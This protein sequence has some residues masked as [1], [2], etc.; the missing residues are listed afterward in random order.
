MMQNIQSTRLYE[1]L[2]FL[3]PAH[4]IAIQEL[5]QLSFMN[6]KKESLILLDCILDHIR[7]T[8]QKPLLK[9][10]LIRACLIKEENFNRTMSKLFMKVRQAL[11]L[12]GIIEPPKLSLEFANFF[13]ENSLP[14]NAAREL[15][16]LESGIKK[17]AIQTHDLYL[18]KSK[19]HAFCLSKQI[20]NR[21]ATPHLLLMNKSLDAFYAGSKLQLLC[22]HANRTRII[23]ASNS[24]IFA[25]GSTA[26]FLDLLHQNNFFESGNIKTYYY[27]Y[28]MLTENEEESYKNAALQFRNYHDTN[29]LP[30]ELIETFIAYLMNQCIQFINKTTRVS[31][32]A[33]HY[34]QYLELLQEEDCLLSKGKLRLSRFQGAI[35]AASITGEI[36]WMRTF[37]EDYGSLLVGKCTA[38]FKEIHLAYI[39]KLVGNLQLAREQMEALVLPR[40]ID[41]L[42]ALTYYKTAIEIYYA[43]KD[44]EQA[45]KTIEA[46]YRFI[47]RTSNSKNIAPVKLK[48]LQKF[49]GYAKKAVKL[50]SKDTRRDRARMQFMEERS[51]VAYATWLDS[52]L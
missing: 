29:K 49:I 27:I 13:I 40:T 21:E 47:R 4:R 2:S 11:P 34:I 41:S 17:S 19:Y 51:T 46:L 45:L 48:G 10:D 12:L 44:I 31:H 32:Y 39:N 28:M 6:Y 35:L 24:P 23:K 38:F 15:E 36:E 43:D 1:L 30:K 18:Q 5:L 22:E 50:P 26:T 7:S 33:N 9:K 16:Q 3:K 8:S 42:F 37:V 52:V 25:V 20:D 14:I